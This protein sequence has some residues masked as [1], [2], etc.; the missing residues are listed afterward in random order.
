MTHHDVHHDVHHAF[1]AVA[2]IENIKENGKYD[3][4]AGE[5]IYIYLENSPKKARALIG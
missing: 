2:H 4:T 1:V 5:S 3:I